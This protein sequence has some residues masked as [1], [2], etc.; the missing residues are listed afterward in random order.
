MLCA[1]LM[2]FI[3]VGLWLAVGERALWTIVR[4]MARPLAVMVHALVAHLM[5]ARGFRVGAT[6]DPRGRAPCAEVMLPAARMLAHPVL[7]RRGP[8][9]VL[10]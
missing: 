2:A 6:E 5:R 4:L 8:P 10:A 3:G 7:L 1:H 9:T